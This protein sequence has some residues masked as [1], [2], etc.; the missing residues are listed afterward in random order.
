MELFP[1][2]SPEGL[3]I[4]TTE[5]KKRKSPDANLTSKILSKVSKEKKIRV[6]FLSFQKLEGRNNVTI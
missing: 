4:V 1:F 6:W 3:I 5:R 2:L